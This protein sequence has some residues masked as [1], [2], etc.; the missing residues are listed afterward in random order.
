MIEKLLTNFIYEDIE[1]DHVSPQMLDD[2]LSKGWYRRKD[3][4]FTSNIEFLEQEGEWM[5]Y[6][7]WWIRYNLHKLDYTAEA[8]RIWNKNRKFQFSCSPLL[9]TEE[10]RALYDRYR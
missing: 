3:T 1:P 7:V 2:Y 4:M 8:K 6:K 5:P 10:L 9:F